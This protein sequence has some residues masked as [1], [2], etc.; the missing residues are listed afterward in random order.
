MR[1]DID[2]MGNL[3]INW[4]FLFTIIDI[5]RYNI[6]VIMLTDANIHDNMLSLWQDAENSI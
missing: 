2:S 4:Y 6:L 1:S 5:T 3:Y